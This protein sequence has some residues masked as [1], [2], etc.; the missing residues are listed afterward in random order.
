METIENVEIF[1]Y[2]GDQIKYD[3]ASTGEAEIN[4]RISLSE[5]KFYQLAKKLTNQHI[6]LRTRTHI[7]NSLIRSRLTYSCQTWNVNEKELEKLNGIYVGMLRKMIR[8]G[9]RKTENHHYFYTNKDVLTICGTDDIQTYVSRQQTS[10]LSHLVRQSNST[11]TKRLTFNNDRVTKRGRPTE[12]L[13]DKVLKVN[14]MTADQF[15][16]SALKREIRY[17]RSD[18]GLDRLKSLKR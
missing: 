3:E 18:D 10:Y 5:A 6:L 1:K 11:L 2:L 14:M 12:T 16:R 17:G 13:E 7:L 9:Y 4:L 8:G 15:Y